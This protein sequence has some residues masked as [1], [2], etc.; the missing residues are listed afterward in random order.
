MATPEV[1]TAARSSAASASPRARV[2]ACK[3]SA[4][5]S[6]RVGRASLASYCSR[7]RPGRGRGSVT[8]G[9]G[10]IAVPAPSGA[11]ARW[12]ATRL[13]GAPVLHEHPGMLGLRLHPLLVLPPLLAMGCA[14]SLS[15]FQPAHV[16]PKG[17]VGLEVGT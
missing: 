17:H 3:L 14:P 6:V 8:I 12:G 1:F 2:I 13:A 7:I 10:N 4:S 11:P 9:G 16:P 15:S 5:G